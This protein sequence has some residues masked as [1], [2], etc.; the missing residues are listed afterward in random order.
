MNHR[1]YGVTEL[2]GIMR[3]DTIIRNQEASV[4]TLLT[5]SRKLHDHSKGLF[6]ALKAR[7]N[8][9]QFINEVYY[10]GVR[11][12]VIS[13][14]NIEIRYYPEANFFKVEDTLQ[15]LQALAAAHRSAF[16]FPVIG[17]TG[18]NGKTIVKEW[19]FHLLYTDY[20]IIRSPKSYN[21]QIGVP[22][23]VWEMA[24]EHEL[25]IFEAGISKSGEMEALA[26]VINPTIGI[27]TNIGEAHKEGFSSRGYP[28]K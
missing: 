14:S 3:A 1:L 10:A 21:S 22:V 6:F 20:H 7:R 11:N 23:S 19:L 27:L 28:T 24:R 4:R 5:D 26:S 12:F 25:A 17:I 15:A 9:H 18:S 8:G 2:R 13:D 16:H